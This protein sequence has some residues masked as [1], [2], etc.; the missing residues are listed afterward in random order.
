VTAEVETSST[1]AIRT[2]V[3]SKDDDPLGFRR[4]FLV[5]VGGATV[6]VHLSRF[7]MRE[8]LKRNDPA[9]EN[10]SPRRRG[11]T[12]MFWDE[13]VLALDEDADYNTLPLVIYR[14]DLFSV[15]VPH[16]IG[17]ELIEMLGRYVNS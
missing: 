8:I 16:D 15:T 4:G 12:T 7:E 1:G 13:L 5:R 14:D 6:V 3:Y 10:P 2:F 11:T 9:D 17:R